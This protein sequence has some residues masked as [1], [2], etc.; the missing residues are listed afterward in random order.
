M[1]FDAITV[2]F[3]L[4]LIFGLF[5]ISK[6]NKHANSIS[7]LIA[8]IL[9]T[10]PLLTGMTEQTNQPYRFMPIIVFFGI[11]VGMLFSIKRV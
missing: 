2:L 3:L 1:I 8:G 10:A 4:P 6:N 5:V 9:L 11:G 7:V